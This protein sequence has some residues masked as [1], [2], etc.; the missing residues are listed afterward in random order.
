M[1]EKNTDLSFIDKIVELSAVPAVVMELMTLLTDP[2]DKNKETLIVKKIKRDPAMATFIYKLCGSPLIGI[3]EQVATVEHALDIIGF[4]RYKSMLMAYFLR[5]LYGKSGKKYIGGYLW[6]HSLYVAFICRELALH[7]E[8]VPERVEEAYIAGLLHDIGKLVLF[9]HDAKTYEPLMFEADRERKEFRSL[10][11]NQYGF[12]HV[13]AGYYLA[14]KWGLA[15]LFKD[16]IRYHHCPGE[17]RGEE[18]IVRLVAFGN[19]TSYYAIV[20]QVELPG[21]FLEYYNLSEE[22]YENIIDKIFGV[23]VDARLLQIN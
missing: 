4:P 2:S 7:L 1:D 21:E 13:E 17:Y 22:K 15:D 6:E 11:E 3:R 9:F 14:E 5:D 16:S 10:E 12:S 19:I 23:L 8:Y 20:K 18:E